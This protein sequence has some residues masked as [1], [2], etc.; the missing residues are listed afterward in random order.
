[1]TTL[2]TEE[3]AT[4]A[5][6]LQ[7][8]RLVQRLVNIVV[9]DLLDRADSHDQSKLE[10]PEVELFAKYTP[11]LAG[12]TYGSPEYAEFLKEMRPALEHHYAKNSHHP[13]HYKNGINDMTLIDLV[14]MF[15][16]WKAATLRHNDGN[17]RKSIEHNAN[18]FGMNPQL[19]KI[20]E[21]TVDMFDEVKG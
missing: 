17:I 18:R 8:I 1:M 21:N 9:R 15:C 10:P 7:H 6:T 16:D 3:Q 11:L 20:F 4:N 2:T 19:V 5:A 13:E 14:E 12:S